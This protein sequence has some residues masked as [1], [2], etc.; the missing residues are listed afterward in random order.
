MAP[1]FLFAIR[2][3]IAK[4]KNYRK[5]ISLLPLKLEIQDVSEE[6]H[7]TGLDRQKNFT[8]SIRENS[9][10]NAKSLIEFLLS[11]SIDHEEEECLRMIKFTVI[12]SS[13][14]PLQ[15][16]NLLEMLEGSFSI[17][18]PSL[19]SP[20][21]RRNEASI[22]TTPKLKRVKSQHREIVYEDIS[23]FPAVSNDDVMDFE[24][25]FNTV[26]G[27]FSTSYLGISDG[28]SWSQTVVS[29]V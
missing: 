21:K 5:L 7:L 12:S 6:I 9:F 10:A 1:S 14:R 29:S 23:K 16:A 18:D 3:N 22:K 25:S 27:M 2:S 24:K 28:K 17:Q 20:F 26:V 11:S 4:E 13:E 19:K 15:T 8:M